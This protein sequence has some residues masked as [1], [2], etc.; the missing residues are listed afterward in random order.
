MFITMMYGLC[1][2]I[3]FL[4]AAFTF[5]NQY[6][7]ERIG[8][9]YFYQQPPAYDDMLSNNALKMIKRSA[10]FFLFNGYWMLSN[11]QIFENSFTF[12]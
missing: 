4:V 8:I 11:R 1:M 7:C 2:P 12:I 6:L 9:A 3:L 5:L 10:P